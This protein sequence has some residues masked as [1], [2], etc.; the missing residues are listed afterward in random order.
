MQKFDF[1]Y[2]VDKK[3][4]D[5]PRARAPFVAIFIFRSARAESDSLTREQTW[6]SMAVSSRC[7][8]GPRARRSRA[9]TPARRIRA[10]PHRGNL[11]RGLCP[12]LSSVSVAQ[13][14][15]GG[16]GKVATH[17]SGKGVKRWDGCITAREQRG[18]IDGSRG[19]RTCAPGSSP[20]G[21]PGLTSPPGVLSCWSGRWTRRQGRA[22][23]R[24]I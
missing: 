23:R 20:P 17:G 10:R 1:S 21:C 15:D 12:C 6:A 2:N 4:Y 14:G 16:Q 8:D 19:A 9:R 13:G 22:A 7:C 18:R 11:L 24:R 3:V 5:Y